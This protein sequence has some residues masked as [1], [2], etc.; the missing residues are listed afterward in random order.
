MP[1]RLS[2]L[3]FL[4]LILIFDFVVGNGINF[5][6]F[7]SYSKSRYDNWGEF[8]SSVFTFEH[9]TSYWQYVVS[10]NFNIFLLFILFLPLLTCLAI[11]VWLTL[12]GKKIDKQTILKLYQF[13]LPNFYQSADKGRI[14]RVKKFLKKGWNIEEPDTNGK[15]AL[16]HAAIGGD[17]KMVEFLLQEGANP[18]FKDKNGDTALSEAAFW[19][20]LECAQALIERGA[21]VNSLDN[22]GV[23]VLMGAAS[24]ATPCFVEYL[25]QN[26]ANINHTDSE[27]DS[28][29]IW[30]IQDTIPT[31]KMIRLLIAHGADKTTRNNNGKTALDILVEEETCKEDKEYLNMLE[32]LKI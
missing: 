5:Y 27:G 12:E 18:N 20:N 26:G 31:E 14:N 23:N 10:S 19:D 8:F 13:L 2:I 3:H 17:P 1:N 11:Y 9:Y 15:T 16:M 30:A 7:Y 24:G 21:D 4:I 6:F 28:V 32:I 25:I 29:L 22:D